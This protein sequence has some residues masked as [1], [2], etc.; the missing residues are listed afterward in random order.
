MKKIVRRIK[1]KKYKYKIKNSYIL[2]K[3][4]KF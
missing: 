1:T 2:N 4:T 3:K